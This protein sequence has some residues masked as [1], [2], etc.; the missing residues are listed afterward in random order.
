MVIISMD[1]IF[2]KNHS[3]YN[4]LHVTKEA[5]E[6]VHIG[7]VHLEMTVNTLLFIYPSYYHCPG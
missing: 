4:L 2:A 5:A 3:G 1:F 7:V 6:I